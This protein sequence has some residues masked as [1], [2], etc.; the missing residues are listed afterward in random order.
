MLFEKS[1]DHTSLREYDVVC[2]W[3][4]ISCRICETLCGTRSPIITFHC[5]ATVH[6]IVSSI[7]R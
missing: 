3:K 2:I 4:H 5:K 7:H 1:E 6:I